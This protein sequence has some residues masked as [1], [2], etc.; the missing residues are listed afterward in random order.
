VEW[1]LNP[2]NDAVR[3]LVTQTLFLTLFVCVYLALHRLL[4]RSARFRRLLNSSFSGPSSQWIILFPFVAALYFPVADVVFE[5][6]PVRT[7]P[8]I[9]PSAVGAIVILAVKNVVYALLPRK[10]ALELW[11]GGAFALMLGFA[12]SWLLGSEVVGMLPW[13]VWV[14]VNE[15]LIALAI[16]ASAYAFPVSIA[17]PPESPPTGKRP[18]RRR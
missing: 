7:L 17:A 13:G 1:L 16:V 18:R 10:P 11:D 12:A 5:S 14:I 3:Y 6:S 9:F 15:A 2:S 8:S 4:L